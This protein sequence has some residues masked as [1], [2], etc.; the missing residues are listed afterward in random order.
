MS[1]A[2][3]AVNQ[4]LYEKIYEE[5]KEEILSGKYRKG[6][7]FPPERLL[8]DR[9][10]TTHLTVRNALAKLVL[11]GYIERY[12]GKGTVVIF[13]RTQAASAPH[14]LRLRSAHV[15]LGTV[16]E[17]NARLLDGLE[18]RLR[19]LSLP[20]RYSCHHGDALLERSLLEQRREPDSVV[21]LEPIDGESSVA[22]SGTELPNTLLITVGAEGFSGPQVLA[23][24]ARGARD[25]VHYLWSLG[26][27]EIALLSSGY[28]AAASLMRQGWEAALSVKGASADPALTAAGVPGVAGGAEGCRQVLARRPGCRAFLCTSDE[29]AAGA[30]RTLAAAGLTPGRDCSV[31]GCGNT[32]LAVALELTT[33]DPCREMICEQ[34]S[35]AVMEAI[36]SGGFTASVRLVPPELKIRSSCGAA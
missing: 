23:D 16:D 7:W 2:A 22:R 9:F 36:S 33:I 32:H 4:Y 24:H 29:G 5:L 31:V 14:R 30:M 35:A 3:E 21:I 27:R 25:A 34:A 11:E 26:H 18:E 13:S 17:G 28:S 19:R 15:V 12:S 1:P 10:N 8:K 20:V 6:D